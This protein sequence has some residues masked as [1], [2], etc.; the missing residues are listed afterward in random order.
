MFIAVRGHA[1]NGRRQV[2]R[3]EHH[4][5]RTMACSPDHPRS[6]LPQF[7]STFE[8][9]GRLKKCEMC[10]APRPHQPP[11]QPLTQS[12]SPV[13]PPSQS[14]KQ[15]YPPDRRDSVGLD[16]VS[17][18]G[19]GGGGV[20]ISGGSG[21]GGGSSDGSGETMAEVEVMEICSPAKRALSEEQKNKIE[22]N[23]LRALEKRRRSATPVPVLADAG[24]PR[25]PLFPVPGPGRV[26]N[27]TPAAPPVTSKRPRV[28]APTDIPA[29]ANDDMVWFSVSGNTGRLSV[30]NPT[31]GFPIGVSMKLEEA[32]ALLQAPTM[33]SAR[34]QLLV[35]VLG[36][37]LVS[38]LITKL[39]TVVG[40][41]GGSALA[42]EQ[43]CTGFLQV[44]VRFL[45]GWMGLRPLDKRLLCDRGLSPSNVL[46][47]LNRL[48]ATA[49]RETE[50]CFERHPPRQPA[51]AATSSSASYASDGSAGAAMG[52]M[53]AVGAADEVR[54]CANSGC[55]VEMPSSLLASAQRASEA[56]QSSLQL[57]LS[58]YCYCR[59]ECAQ[60][61]AVVSG[62]ST[63]IR[64]QIFQLEH[65]VCQ[66]C[67]VDAHA[68]FQQLQAL[69]P[70]ERLQRLMGT[71]FPQTKRIVENPREDDFWQV[72]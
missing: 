9:E 28:S 25:P 69:S 55:Q 7:T 43:L 41:G 52:T 40:T 32:T 61:A 59:Y 68:L 58:K 6:T 64:H 14:P 65:G 29:E 38:V 34:R 10:F 70:A 71:H 63:P 57:Q 18:V 16:R 72:N 50:P 62:R 54:R 24:S 1:L 22:Q 3:D 44:L 60:E 4:R 5:P 51:S 2:A 27:A 67:Q 8:N 26:S 19:G 30:L 48:Q 13:Q 45:Q 23:R 49:T 12:P 11:S 21:S 37:S 20:D 47:T 46:A 15:R 36:E 42:I 31:S 53:G 33:H 66:L 17:S 56:S 39:G 35:S